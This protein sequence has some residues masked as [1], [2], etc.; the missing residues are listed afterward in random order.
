MNC[1]HLEFQA[2]VDVSRLSEGEGGPI[3]RYN[4]Q[5]RIKCVHCGLD[6]IFPGLPRGV[7]LDEPM[8][9]IFGIEARLPIRPITQADKGS[10]SMT[11]TMPT[12]KAHG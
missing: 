5:I 4:A 3:T 9:G 1:E 7:N 6:F 2:H 12:S 10:E 11:V 8:A